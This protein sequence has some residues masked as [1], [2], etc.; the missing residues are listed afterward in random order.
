MEV[1]DATFNTF[2]SQQT[3]A[4]LMYFYGR[5]CG[6]CRVIKP[7][8]VELRD[9]LPIAEIEVESCPM[10]SRHFKIRS[11]PTLAVVK[12]GRVIKQNVGIPPRG[13]RAFV[14]EAGALG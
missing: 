1:K 4:Y 14:V 3:G 8:I 12:D 11:V 6:P 13:V 5:N 10:L 9:A 2:V 7:Q